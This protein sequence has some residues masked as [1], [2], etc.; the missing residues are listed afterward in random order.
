MSKRIYRFA[1]AAFV[2]ASAIAVSAV[3]AGAGTL[4]IISGGAGGFSPTQT[5]ADG[6]FQG[7]EFRK[8]IGERGSPL[9]L[10][11]PGHFPRRPLNAP[12]VG[13]TA[14]TTV[15]P[16][17]GVSVNGLNFRDQRLANGGNQFSV[18]P[19]DQALC[20]AGGKALEAV[21][22]VLRVKST[23]GANL[24]GVMDSNSFYGYPAQFNR[25]TFLQGP[26]MTD[27]ICYYDPEHQRWM[28]LYL[29][30]DVVPA[31]G[32][33]TGRNH[34]DL[35]VS[36]TADPRGSWTL[37]S[38]P[39][40]NDGTEGTPV[41]PNCPCIGDY[42]HIGADRN[43]I[44]IVTNEYSFFGEGFNGSQIYAIS[45]QQL[46]TTPM[47]IDVH[48]FENTRVD[49]TP[50]FTV[51]P[52][53]SPAGHYAPEA[54]GTEYFLSTIAGD[55]S[56]TGNPTGTAQDIGLFAIS[57]TSSIDSS[58]PDMRLT[59]TLVSSQRYTFPPLSDQK[60]GDFPLGQC[61]ND[62]TSPTP[63]GPGCWQF[64]F[65][66]ADEPDHDETISTPD[67]LDSRMQQTFY[68]NG[69]VWGSWGTGVRVADELKAGIAYAAVRPKLQNGKLRGGR[70]VREGYVAV[71]NNNLS[72]P[73]LAMLP[74]GKGL[75]AATL[76]GEGYHPSAAYIP[77]NADG[78]HGDVHVAATGVGVDDGF[79]SYKAFVGDPP[80]TRWG[81]YG[82][83]WVDGSDIWIASE[84]IAQSCTLAQ[85]MAAPF[86]S[87]GGT[88]TSLG[89]W[90]TRIS[91][92]T[93]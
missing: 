63:F 42:P 86:G 6:V 52:T 2:V 53:T 16:G 21:N 4:P 64:F 65:L 73:A 11:A 89:N 12:V 79:T 7:R 76:I 14:V 54:G 33:F 50:G 34:L 25:T 66:P 83:A 17:L 93:P 29:T 92:V 49:D 67:S 87:C 39:A 69:L 88:R 30:L 59:S 68:V 58:S 9:A 74:S 18:E 55:G 84:W 77:L 32:D 91:Q 51:W 23:S 8:R 61:L 80:R 62:T 19:P 5:G 81:D 38:I 3:P 27:P 15:N 43:A 82:A 35:A 44:F 41:H 90:A 46:S 13:S 48:L 1:V 26:F 36:D 28:L 10:D 40:Q 24:T 57:N 45:K 47:S 22:T 85:Y 56:E 78:S 60:P 31:T 75:I 20:V 71:A 70:T 37:Y 72:M